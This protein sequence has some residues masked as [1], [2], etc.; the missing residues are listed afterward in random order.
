ML[1]DHV[2]WSRQEI[3]VEGDMGFF[4]TKLWIVYAITCIVVKSPK[5]TIMSV[6]RYFVSRFIIN[7]SL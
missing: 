2:Q 7:M 3:F 4:P 5:N 6:M 1:H